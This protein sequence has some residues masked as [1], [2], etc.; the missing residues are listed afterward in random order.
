MKVCGD[1]LRGRE[2]LHSI[3]KDN[4]QTGWETDD[5]KEGSKQCRNRGNS[6][7]NRKRKKRN[8]GRR[9]IVI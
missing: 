7:V 1:T 6:M 3:I 8:V 9:A 5:R 2:K 4:L